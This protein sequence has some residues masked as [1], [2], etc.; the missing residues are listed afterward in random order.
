M[1]MTTATQSL[2]AAGM[3]LGNLLTAA[4][5]TTVVVS[6]LDHLFRAQTPSGVL[7]RETVLSAIVA[8]GLGYVAYYIRRSA[9]SKWVWVA[10]LAWFG[11]GALLF[12]S[13][14]RSLRVLNADHSIYWEMSGIGC[15]DFASLQSCY[16]YFGYT[17][18]SLRTISYSIGAFCCS[19][20]GTQA[21]AG[22][23]DAILNPMRRV[24]TVP[25][26]TQIDN[27]LDSDTSVRQP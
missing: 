19:R 25:E 7:R 6:G 23:E 15:N 18:Q 5:G 27:Q 10:G 20:V 24:D 17:L 9:S 3:F 14:Q 1:T 11:L 2:R 16:D 21:F 4:F 22:I 12:W 13:G 26:T 8:F